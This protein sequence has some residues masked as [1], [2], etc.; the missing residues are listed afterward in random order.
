[1]IE[2]RFESSVRGMQAIAL[3]QV[4]EG[5]GELVREYRKSHHYLQVNPFHN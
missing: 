5:K 2:L 4:S 3:E 1:M